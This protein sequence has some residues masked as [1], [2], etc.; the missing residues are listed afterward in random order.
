[1][2]KLPTWSLRGPKFSM[3]TR[4]SI[5]YHSEHVLARLRANS[6][7]EVVGEYI[8]NKSILTTKYWIISFNSTGGVTCDTL[9]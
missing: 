8:P 5:V 9:N 1:M 2:L 3:H 6:Y 4:K 7:E